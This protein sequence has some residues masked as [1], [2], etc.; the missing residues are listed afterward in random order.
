MLSPTML[1]TA[2][3]M[4]LNIMV[5]PTILDSDAA[6]PR[7]QSIPSALALLAM[8]LAYAQLDLVLPGI[9][10]AL[11]VILWSLVAAYRAS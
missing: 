7:L 1:L 8:T 2:G 9:A 3:G 11:G 6:V 10:T 5:F 4:V